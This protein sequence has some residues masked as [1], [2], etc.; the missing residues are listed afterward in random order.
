MK[1][2]IT[3]AN[4][5]LGHDI[6]RLFE[7]KHDLISL[8]R[9]PSPWV[10]EERF[11]QCD[12]TNAA[13]T[14]AIITKE[15]PELVIHCAAFNDVDRA[16]SDPDTAYRVNAMGTRNVAL[17]CQRFDATMISVSTDY[18]FDGESASATGYREF[19][20]CNPISQYG[21]SKLWGERFVQSLLTKY[22]IVR[23]SW[24]FGPSRDAWVDRVEQAARA[25]EPIFSAKDLISSPTYTPDLAQ[26]ILRLAESRHYGIYHLTNQGSCSRTEL[27]EEVL[28]IHNLNRGQLIQSMTRDELRLRAKRPRF[29]VMENYA[30]KLDGFPPM[31]GWKEALRAHFDSKKKV[32][33]S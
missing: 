7:H 26:G 15:N 18:V 11:R 12:L 6:W 28:S 4:G 21:S 5:L 17:A 19:D 2:L 29:S 23:T 3:G 20:P 16:E 32:P 1:V 10:G 31:R 9:N 30:W 24:L 25:G 13:L 33:T 22:F 8:A 27:A 14:Y